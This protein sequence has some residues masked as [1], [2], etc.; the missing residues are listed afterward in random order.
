MVTDV[1]Q[2][3]PDSSTLCRFVSVTPFWDA[4]T[5]KPYIVICLRLLVEVWDPCCGTY[6]AEQ[7]W[8]GVVDKIWVPC[9]GKA[10]GKG[11]G[12]ATGKGKGR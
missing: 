10:R 5:E 8:Q 11:R 3:M 12:G 4:A 7:S 6:S 1:T 9:Q 2:G